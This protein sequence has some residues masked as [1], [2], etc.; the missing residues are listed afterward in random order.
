MPAE[1]KS[2]RDLSAEFGQTVRRHSPPGEPAE[3]PA[4]GTDAVN[5]IPEPEPAGEE[6]RPYSRLYVSWETSDQLDDEH[7]QI[8]RRT[9]G[10]I[11]K[12]QLLDALV[13]VALRHRDEVEEEL[14]SRRS[15]KQAP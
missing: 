2:A 3:E 14:R 8:R 12:L 7:R 13:A 5:A 11:S 10:R 4:P 15:R 1:R 6:E 9:R